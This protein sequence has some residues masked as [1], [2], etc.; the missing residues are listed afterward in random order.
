V[1]RTHHSSVHQGGLQEF[2]LK[3]GVVRQRG[4]PL[5]PDQKGSAERLIRGVLVDLPTVKAVLPS[6]LVL[7]V[8]RERE[9]NQVWVC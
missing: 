6:K 1:L 8:K 2:A 4:S 9:A 7:A 5:A 3:N